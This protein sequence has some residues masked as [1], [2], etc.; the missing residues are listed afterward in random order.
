MEAYKYAFSAILIALY[1]YL[2][3]RRYVDKYRQGGVIN[4]NHEEKPANITPPGLALQIFLLLFI[5]FREATYFK[6]GIPPTLTK[7]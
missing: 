7:N 1:Y 5:C 6:Y 3:A 4:T 2:F